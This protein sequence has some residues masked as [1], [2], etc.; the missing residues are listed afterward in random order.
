L[1]SWQLT[2]VEAYDTQ[3][4][5]FSMIAATGLSAPFPVLQIPLQKWLYRFVGEEFTEQR[6][7]VVESRSGHAQ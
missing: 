4:A 3:D 5:M 7:A 1:E 6:I 2:D